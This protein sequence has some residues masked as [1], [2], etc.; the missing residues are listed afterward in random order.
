M[1]A[2][3]LKLLRPVLPYLLAA[4][5]A[6]GLVAY[7]ISLRHNLASENQKNALLTADNQADLAAIAAYRAQQSR[8]E[9]A[10]ATLDAQTLATNTSATRLSDTIAAAPTS[11]D[12]PVAPVLARTLNG[13]RA[14]QGGAP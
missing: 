6:L 12:G 2:I 7:I 9:A 11:D 1:P 10:L 3:L 5:A 4:A 14:L 8:Y 13:L